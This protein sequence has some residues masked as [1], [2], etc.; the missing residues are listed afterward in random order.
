MREK[1]TT[2]SRQRKALNITIP[3]EMIR[4][5]KK[6]KI[7]ASQAA[8]KAIAEEIR[9]AKEQE[10]IEQNKGAINAYNKRIEKEGLLIESWWMR[11]DHGTV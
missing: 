6:Y 4:E 8:Q 7:N 5:T 10:W 1:N 2:P 9:K 3:A 11:G